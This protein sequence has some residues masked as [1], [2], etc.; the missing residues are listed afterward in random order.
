MD[1][2]EVLLA[3]KEN[4]AA[5][6]Q[7]I[8][9]IQDKETRSDWVDPEEAAVI[10]GLNIT[11]SKVHRANLRWLIKV[12][13]L[14]QFRPGRPPVYYRNELERVSKKIASGEIGYVGRA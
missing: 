9:L 3:I 12:G 4:T 14:K 2:G 10:L 13:F 8:K 11:K 7:L 6:N 5:L 1:A